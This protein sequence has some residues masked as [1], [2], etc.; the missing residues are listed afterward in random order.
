MRTTTSTSAAAVER[1][2]AAFVDLLNDRSISDAS[3]VRLLEQ[4][5]GELDGFIQDLRSRLPQ[6]RPRREPPQDPPRI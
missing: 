3:R 4:L 5:C 2:R 6:P 1:A